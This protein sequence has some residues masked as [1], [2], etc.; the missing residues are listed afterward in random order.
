[1][2]DRK[3]IS[4]LNAIIKQL[5]SNTILKIPQKLIETLE[6]NATFPVEYIKPD[7]PLEEL[8]LE[9]E[10][11]EILAIIAYYYFCTEPER[12]EWDKQLEKNEELYQNYLRQKYDVNDLLKK[13]VESTKEDILDKQEMII[14]QESFFTK[15]I[16]KIK[17]WLLKK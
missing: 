9:E 13:E 17:Q 11:K 14:Y 3:V 4:E 12:K 15:V 6:E 2:K 8:K 1:M 5:D 10:T 7:I 16:N